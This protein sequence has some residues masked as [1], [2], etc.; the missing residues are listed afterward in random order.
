MHSSEK[1]NNSEESEKRDDDVEKSKAMLAA[2]EV[3][4]TEIIPEKLIDKIPLSIL[5]GLGVDSVN[6]LH[7]MGTELTHDLVKTYLL[8]QKISNDMLAR[9]VKISKGIDIKNF[10]MNDEEYMRHYDEVMQLKDDNFAHAIEEDRVLREGF[11]TRK[12]IAD[13]P[14]K[15]RPALLTVLAK[16]N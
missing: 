16:Q 11:R 15:L 4:F 8:S 9:D 1:P 3:D 5:A 2:F 13:V 12:Q 10:D 7:S 14:K 6:D